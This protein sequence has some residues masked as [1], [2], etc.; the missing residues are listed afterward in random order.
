MFHLID[1]G[2]CALHRVKLVDTRQ[3]TQILTSIGTDE[4]GRELYRQVWRSPDC[5][6]V[7]PI[8]PGGAEILRQERGAAPE[9]PVLLHDFSDWTEQRHE[10]V[11]RF[12]FPVPPERPTLPPIYAVWSG[13]PMPGTVPMRMLRASYAS[14]WDA[15]AA[16]RPGDQVVRHDYHSG[17]IPYLSQNPRFAGLLMRSDESG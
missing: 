13:A 7:C 8:C 3:H 10:S 1:T 2:E 14:R 17:G 11:Q 16:Q 6:R 4:G 9:P 5:I 15:A 12:L